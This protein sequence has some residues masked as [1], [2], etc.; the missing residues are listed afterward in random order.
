MEVNLTYNT[1]REKLTMPEYGRHIQEL[2]EHIKTLETKEERQ[3]WAEKAVSLM[4]QMSPN[5]KRDTHEFKE[6][7]WVHLFKISNYELD[8]MPPNGEIPKAE[9]SALKPNFLGYPAR[10]HRY[11]HYGQFVQ[12]LVEKAIL[13]EEGPKKEEFKNIIGSYMKLAYKNWSREHYV[14]DIV[15]KQ[16]LKKLSEERL[17]IGEEMELNKIKAANRAISTKQHSKS[18]AKKGGHKSKNKK[19]KKKKY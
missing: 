2:I 1:Q 9:E 17:I 6:K 4:L 7:M 18:K 14:N 11:R 16:E 3:K 13:M 19:Y 15:I 5:N 12:K 8:V 10:N